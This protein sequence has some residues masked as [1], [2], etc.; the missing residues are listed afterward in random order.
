VIT[1]TLASHLSLA[2][3]Y[4]FYL[5]RVDLSSGFRRL[6]LRSGD[7]LL[8][9]GQHRLDGP[10]DLSEFVDALQSGRPLTLFIER[11]GVVSRISTR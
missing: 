11:N 2:N 7:I 6:G 9:I 10:E 4:G 8:A 1:P 5:D 3:D